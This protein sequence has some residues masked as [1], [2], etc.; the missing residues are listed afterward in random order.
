MP[1][2]QWPPS[3][4]RALWEPL[5]DLAEQRFKGPR[6]ESRWLNL[7]GFCLRPGTG[8]PL[9]EVRVKALWPVFHQGVRHTKDVQCWT[10]WWVLWRRVAAGLSRPHHDEV[11]RR[12]V[13]FLLPPKTGGAHPAR[14][15]GRP[16]PEAHELAEIW[17]CAAS[18][19]RL[20][21]EHKEPLGEA[22]VKELARPGSG[23]PGYV[24]W[25]LGRLGARVLLFGPANATVPLATAARWAEALLARPYAPG[26]EAADA[27]FA[28][29][30]L[31]RVSGDRVRDLDEPLRARILARLAEL[32]ADETTLRPVREYHELETEQQGQ[33]L[34][35]ALPVGLRLVGEP[36]AGSRA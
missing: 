5:R 9:D 12:L 17:R 1:R 7:A 3:A 11:Y 22:L 10:E 2:D 21:A 19:E 31:G 24:L 36:A 29:A 34:G 33:A 18:L 15:A 23:L 4:L 16:R 28:L 26:R 32:G 8:F 30:Q 27:I 20:G 25:C 6:H 35:D 13:P 14:K